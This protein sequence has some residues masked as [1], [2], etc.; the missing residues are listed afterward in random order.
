MERIF[1]DITKTPAFAESLERLRAGRELSM[2]GLWGSSHALVAAALAEST[3]GCMLLVVAGVDEAD[4]MVEDLE[5]FRPGLARLF[6]AWETLDASDEPPDPLI[7]S[8]RLRVLGELAARKIGTVP[9]LSGNTPLV[10]RQKSLSGG[11]EQPGNGE[12]K[13]GTVPI[14]S[15][16]V[17]VTPVQGLLQAVAAPEALAENRLTLEV[18][19]ERGP[20]SVAEW[21]VERGFEASPWVDNPGEFSRRGGILDVYPNDL[22]AAVRVEFFGDTVES[23][24]L[25]DVETQRST[26]E[27][28]RYEFRAIGGAALRA[29]ERAKGSVCLIEY[30]G[31][32]ALFAVV[33]PVNVQDRAKAYLATLGDPRGTFTFEA[34]VARAQRL[35]RVFLE[36][37]GGG[38]AVP[39]NVAM[40]EAFPPG[41]ENIVQGLTRLLEDVDRLVVFC[42]NAAE[43]E[44]LRET[45]PAESAALL[46][47]IVVRMGRVNQGF[48]LLDLR[49]AVVG[50]HE[51][52]HR[53]AVR[54]PSKASVRARPLEAFIDLDKGDV[55]VHAEHGLARYLGTELLERDGTMQEFLALEFRDRVRIYVPS[56]R[57]NLVQKYVGGFEGRPMLSVYGG[58]AWEKKKAQV[59]EALKGLAAEMLRL[60]AV[61]RTRAGVSCPP[62]DRFQKEFEAEFIYEETE[63]QLT[64]LEELKRDMEST[65]PMDRL[66]CGDVGYGKTELAMRAA[67]KAAMSGRQVAVL[68]PTTVLAQQHYETFKE[69]MADYPL[70]IEVIS[71]FR[72]KAEQR[73]I[74]EE[75]SAGRIDVLIGTHR[76]VQAD[77]VFHDLGLVVVDEEQR[78]GVQHKEHFKR[79]RETVDVLTLTATPIPRTLHM[80]LLGIRDISTLETPPMDRQAIETHVSRFDARR[81]RDAVL[82][83]LNRDGQVFF[84]HDRVHNIRR[85]A[86]TVAEAVPEARLAVGHGQM[87]ERELAAHMEAFVHRKVDVLVSTTIVESGLDIPNANTIFINNADRFGLADLHQLR[88]RVG[89]YRHRAYAYF[90]IDPQRRV[91]PKAAKRLKAIEDYTELGAGFR[92]ALRDLEIRGAGNILGPEQSG[93]IAAIGYDLYC[94][95]LERAIKELRNEAVEERPETTIHIGLAAFLPDDFVPDE[96]DRLSLYRRLERARSAAE[97]APLRGELVDRFGPSRRA[98]GEG[99]P[100][101][102]EA[103]FTLHNLR[104]LLERHGIVALTR[105][106][107]RL[108]F[109]FTD[110]AKFLSA[111][112]PV[113]HRL[114]LIDD[115]TTSPRSW[116]SS[117]ISSPGRRRCA[118]KRAIDAAPGPVIYCCGVRK[119]HDTARGSRH[120]DRRRRVFVRAVGQRAAAP[121]AEGAA[122][123]GPRIRGVGDEGPGGAPAGEGAGEGVASERARCA[124]RPRAGR[125]G[126][127][128]LRPR[129]RRRRLGRRGGQRRHHHSRG[130]APRHPAAARGDREGRGAHRHGARGEAPRADRRGAAAE[131]GAAARAPGGPPRHPRRRGRA[132]RGGRQRHDQR[133]HARTRL[134]DADGGDAAAAGPH[135]RLAEAGGDR[136]PAHPGAAR[137]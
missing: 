62:D 68:V 65:R 95:M 71:R 86:Q 111:T 23:I 58:T 104:L 121:D 109:S 110:A 52:F 112:K 83:E 37:F 79:L 72:T 107:D 19:Q 105:L 56:T 94:R 75:L 131:S 136:Q 28:K 5:A 117:G 1:E 130:G 61:R 127:R 63:D 101:P 88:G 9:I 44:R 16:A 46:D 29:A 133:P 36:T 20:D 77:V 12:G 59:A 43:A 66:I 6:P 47:R 24:R 49:T 4:R 116:L 128:H 27:V 98:E 10:A 74:L 99:L 30:L 135:G 80:S 38:D 7:V 3:G 76:L 113:Q 73:H 78:F 69:R 17:V 91:T 13:I 93:H 126:P 11:S 8:Q 25:F 54:R 48:K 85:I 119:G 45:V 33:E 40:P 115:R 106:H 60:Q 108:V 84:V 35:R 26:T 114:R 15:P 18:G 123:L 92:I 64:V 34:A 82:R 21:L 2:S 39:F 70:V 124:R 51:I 31:D 87:S 81:I 57:V 120:P 53:Y 14:F 89:R 100:A 67:F 22:S 102:V 125:H 132:H 129:S 97:F 137:A 50:H 32:D 118:E 134:H 103:L 96:K 41:L 90:L 42:N 55:V 122:D